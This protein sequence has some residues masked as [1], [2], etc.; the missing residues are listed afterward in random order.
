VYRRWL[1]HRTQDGRR[2]LGRDL[3]QFGEPGAKPMMLNGV[4]GAYLPSANEFVPEDVC[5]AELATVRTAQPAN[6]G[7]ALAR[8]QPQTIN[9]PAAMERDDWPRVGLSGDDGGRRFRVIGELEEW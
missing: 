3:V 6:Q 4:Y 1:D 9:V 2:R 7:T 8:R 5:R